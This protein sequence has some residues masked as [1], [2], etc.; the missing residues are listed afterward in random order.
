MFKVESIEPNRILG[1]FL[2]HHGLSKLIACWQLQIDTG[3]GE[4][5]EKQ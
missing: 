3:I 1:G 5:K 2:Y 4:R